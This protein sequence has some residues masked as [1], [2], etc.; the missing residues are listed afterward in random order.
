MRSEGMT[1]SSEHRARAGEARGRVEPFRG[2]QE[3]P[4]PTMNSTQIQPKGGAEIL[5]MVQRKRIAGF[6]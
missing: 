3:S 5:P 2:D 6:L 1:G 4:V